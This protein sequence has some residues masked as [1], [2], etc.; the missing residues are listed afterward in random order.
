MRIPQ[1]H[2]RLS[3]NFCRKFDRI[4][5]ERIKKGVDKKMLSDTRISDALAKDPDFDIIL[6]RIS[7]MPRQEDLK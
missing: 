7:K 4:K 2:R 6:G 5:L 3:R 1:T